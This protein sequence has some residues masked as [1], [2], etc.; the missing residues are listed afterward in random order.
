[1]ACRGT[2]RHDQP[3]KEASAVLNCT[4]YASAAEGINGTYRK[5]QAPTYKAEENN[6]H[7]LTYLMYLLNYFELYK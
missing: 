4:H 6:K 2:E 3:T 5:R 1:M 7:M